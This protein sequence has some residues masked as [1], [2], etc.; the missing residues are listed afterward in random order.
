MT[1]IN[2]RD[3]ADDFVWI[4]LHACVP[5]VAALTGAICLHMWSPTA[6]EEFGMYVLWNLTYYTIM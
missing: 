5:I 1:L 3:L 6:G 2:A 4:L